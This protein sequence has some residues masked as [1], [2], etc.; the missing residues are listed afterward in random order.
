MFRSTGFPV[1]GLERLTAPG[2]SATADACLA[3]EVTTAAFEAEYARVLAALAPELARIAANE[4]VREALTWERSA[5]VDPSTPWLDELSPTGLPRLDASRLEPARSLARVWQRYCAVNDTIGF[6][7][8]FKWITLDPRESRT[9]ADPGPDLLSLRKVFF[10]PWGLAACGARL[11]A[12]P[13][14]R[15]WLPPYRRSHHVLEGLTVRRAGKPP[16]EVT[17]AQA[18]ALA[19][20]DGRRPGMLV[21]ADL[22]KQEVVPDTTAALAL[23]D[24]LVTERLLEW[25]E[26]LPITPCTE[27]VLVERIAAIEDDKI[28]SVAADGFQRMRRARAAVAAAAGDAEALGRAL[29]ELERLFT[30][31]TGRAARRPGHG[32]PGNGVVYEDALRNVTVRLGREVLTS[33][34][35]ALAIVLQAARWLTAELGR[36]FDE[37]L[38]GLVRAVKGRRPSLADVWDDAVAILLTPPDADG[39]YDE[40][41]QEFDARWRDLLDVDPRARAINLSSAALRGPAS[42]LFSA[43]RPGWSLARVHSPDLLLCAPSVEAINQGSYTAVLGELHIAY[44][45]LCVRTM[46]WA[47]PVTDAF[48]RYAVEDYGGPRMIPLMP[49]LWS[50]YAGRSLQFE[51]ERTDRQIGFARASGLDADRAVATCAIPIEETRT[52]LVGR[53]PDGATVPLR[54]FFAVFLSM[55]CTNALREVMRGDHTPRVTINHLVVWREA[56]HLT[57]EEIDSLTVVDEPSLYLSV[58]RLAAARGMPARCFAR[59]SSDRKPVYVDFTSPVYVSMLGD[60]IRAGRAKDRRMEVTFTEMLPTPDHAWLRDAEGNSYLAEFRLHVTDP[61]PPLR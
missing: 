58:R 29:N 49:R 38:G 35:P 3:G 53:L 43:E 46:T 25:D 2:L 21:A 13:T 1:S 18:A 52:G 61:A 50:D 55:A 47:L 37:A 4:R 45:T 10:E 32:H 33:V 42:R 22:V 59:L 31:I 19:A 26:N 56:W 41:R 36:R 17:P 57:R 12:D 34:E 44:A 48:F 5:A 30:D 40:V 51:D 23:L 24:G 7:G 11:R 20:C 54:E 39:L 6:F 28:R 14:V 27:E 60:M 16:V 15:R 9:T 8:P